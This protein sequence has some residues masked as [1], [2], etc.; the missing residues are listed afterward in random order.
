V[1]LSCG[2]SGCHSFTSSLSSSCLPAFCSAPT[3]SSQ[4]SHILGVTVEARLDEAFPHLVTQAGLLAFTTANY[5][6][7]GAPFHEKT[8]F[9]NGFQPSSEQSL[10]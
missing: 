6:N 7:A 10:Y 8:T 1:D 5:E 4:L 9:K 2:T 3:L